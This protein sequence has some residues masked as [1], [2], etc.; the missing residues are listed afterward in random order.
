MRRQFLK[1]AGVLLA[2]AALPAAAAP[3]GALVIIGGALRPDTA[4]VWQRIVAL[5]GGP[6]A[7]IAVMPSAAARPERS[8]ANIAATLKR[9]GADAFVV[10]VAV[11]LAGSDYRARADDAEL[12]AAVR[13][14]GGV[15][16]AGG[17]QALVTQA[18]LR[19]DGSRSAVLQAVWDVY[20]R[21]GVIAGTSAG[22]AI[23]SST[24]FHAP[25]PTLA[26]L[27]QGLTPG[28]DLAPGLGFIGE[29]VFI[30]QHFLVRGRF[31]RMLPAMLQAG[32]KLGIGVDEN[33]AVVVRAQREL[34]VVGYKGVLMADLTQ[35]SAAPG[36]F[37]VSNA[38]LSYLDRG[39]RYD[40]A[41]GR[42]TPA[43][44][45]I[46]GRLDAARPALRGPAYANDI[47]ANNAIVE[48]M[49]KLMDGDQQEALGIAAGDPRAVPPQPSFHFRLTR[50]TASVGY[51]SDVAEAYS[52]LNVRLDAAPAA[53]GAANR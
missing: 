49:E 31:A 30:D 47:L 46:N 9:Y 24:M 3:S 23:M 35:A 28:R 12:V 19:P 25:R 2:A 36:P 1:A 40:L 33:T 13:G 11:R 20:Q 50:D 26:M 6:G 32:Y 18:L 41:T 37:N 38:R 52:L 43:P 4:E 21:G 10:P 51:A 53:Q 22:A 42:H 5:A 7:R 34:E 39:D 16:F 8:G 27:Q 15:Y 29:Q 14:A 17:D 48:L 45:K 44:D